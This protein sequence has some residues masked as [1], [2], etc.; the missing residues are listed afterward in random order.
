VASPFLEQETWARTAFGVS[1]A[2]FVLGEASRTFRLRR[3]ASRADLAG[4]VVFRIIF[5]AGI[6][7]LPLVRA[8]VPGATLGG[9][10]VFV[11]G[12]AVGWLGLGLRWWSFATLGRYFTTV[13]KTST[14][15][16]VVTRG[17]YRWLRHP[18]YTGLLLA[19]VGGGLMLGNWVGVCVSLAL[20][21]W[22]LVYRIGREE[23]A[24][25]AALGD[26]YLACMEGRARLV[27]YVW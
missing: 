12:L 10:G 27:P 15:Q 3:G 14:D 19:I 24:L 26:P 5:L 21:V 13:V 6:G 17:P 25:V 23:G 4:E 22:S 8:L 11:L 2:A 7:V 20:V 9:A 16:E 18:S 1:V